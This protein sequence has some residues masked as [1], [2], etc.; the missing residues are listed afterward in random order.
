[1]SSTVSW[2]DIRDEFLADIDD[3][4]PA[5]A[6]CNICRWY[7]PAH[8]DCDFGECRRHAPNNK[9]PLVRSEMLCGDWESD[10]DPTPR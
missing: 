2:S 3:V 6:S 1:M 9:W 4:I 8:N 7:T 10:Y 5:H